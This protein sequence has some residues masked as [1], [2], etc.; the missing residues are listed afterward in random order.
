MNNRREHE[1]I[2][3]LITRDPVRGGPL[4]VTRLES[5][6]SNVVIEGRF[7]L[8]W[9]ARLTPEQLEFAGLLVKNRGNIQKVAAE[10]N[11]AYN[12]ARNHLDEIVG[13]LETPPSPFWRDGH[14][15]PPTPPPPP[16]VFSHLSR[17]EVIERLSRGEI[18]PEEAVR[19][20]KGL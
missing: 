15:G 12:T 4:L 7:S 18:E 11:I 19:L 10:M 1:V 14:S 13:A 6:E 5:P 17:T 8:G 2:N 3:P 9:M 20:L 16:H